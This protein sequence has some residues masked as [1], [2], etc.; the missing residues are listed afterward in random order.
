MLLPPADRSAA[1]RFG[2][3]AIIS[4]ASIALYW[5]LNPTPPVVPPLQCFTIT[6]VIA[7]LWGGFGPGLFAAA[8]S[9]IATAFLFHPQGSSISQSPDPIRFI[10]FG[11]VA[12]AISAIADALRRSAR[13]E[14]EQRKIWQASEH[15]WHELA[16]AMQHLVWTCRADGYCDFLSSQWVAYTGRPEAEQLGFG[17]AEAVHPA[18][19]EAALAAWEH[20]AKTESVLDTEFRIRRHDGEYRWFKTRAVPVRDATGRIAKWYGS[21]TDVE[22]LK[23]AQTAATE[24]AEQR[25]LAV[26]AADM[27]AWDWNLK[28]DSVTWSERAYSMFG[29][30]KGETGSRDR[31][32]AAVHP[33]DRERVRATLNASLATPP[34]RYQCEYRVLRPDGSLRWLFGRGA[35]QTDPATGELTHMVGI[36]VDVTERVLGAEKLA[37]ALEAAEAANRAKDSFL[38]SLSHE[39]RT[40]LTPVLFL[41]A[42]LERSS[43]LPETLR[44][45]F[46]MIRRNVELEARLIDDLL[47][48]TRIT[49]GKLHLDLVPVALHSIVRRSIELLRGDLE[50]KHLALTLDL[51]A[52]H[53][54]ASADAVRLQQVFWNVL[55]NAVKFTPEGGTISVRSRGI[56]QLTWHLAIEDSGLGIT[57]DELPT[58]FDAFAQGGEAASHRFGGLGLGLAISSLLVKEHG[59]RIW[60]ESAGRDRGSTFHI[61]LPLLPDTAEVPPGDATPT[62]SPRQH[63]GRILIVEDHEATRETLARLLA[64]RGFAVEVAETASRA[65]SV[66]ATHTF[67]LVISDLGLPD[68]SGRELAAEFRRAYGLK[69]IALS[70]YGM[71]E[72]VRLSH[73][74]G[75]LDHVTKPVDI[76]TLHDS[77]IAALQTEKFES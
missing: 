29:V 35:A 75:F 12:L 65:R 27:G 26:E 57:S 66:A 45:D 74:A 8:I 23:R 24:A 60:A 64:R 67:D 51:D 72:D 32:M 63:S 37:T 59:G 55:K 11:A 30:P 10:T 61:E 17:W 20:A 46:A 38:A 43:E 48:L 2:L 49:R 50:R 15:R 53:D 69:A 18:D 28:T 6:V 68:G 58:I 40:P 21:N 73:S 5:A 41:A 9:A 39:L 71:E 56:A 14:G 52:E 70:G 7:A 22:D 54:Y 4:A 3:A 77:I 31:F 25:M 44:A 16:E 47:D 13:R 34:H 19:R 36:T 42:S 62:F 1:F 76:E 33:D